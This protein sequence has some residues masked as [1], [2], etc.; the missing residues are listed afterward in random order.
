MRSILP[1]MRKKNGFRKLPLYKTND[2][3]YYAN[4]NSKQEALKMKITRIGSFVSAGFYAEI[5]PGELLL[6]GGR[7]SELTLD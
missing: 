7:E 1:Y 6:G 3:S 5:F 2:I 4:I